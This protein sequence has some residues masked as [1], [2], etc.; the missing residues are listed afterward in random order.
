MLFPE[1]LCHAGVAWA[2]IEV[3]VPE[4]PTFVAELRSVQIENEHFV[5]GSTLKNFSFS[6]P[7]WHSSGG[8]RQARPDFL[9]RQIAATGRAGIV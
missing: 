3:N 8:A 4:N 1:D 2:A 9:R 7:D 6:A 5:R